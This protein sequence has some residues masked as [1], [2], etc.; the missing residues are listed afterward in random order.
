M[1]MMMMMID[2]KFQI[3]IIEFLHL[4]NSNST[5]IFNLVDPRMFDL[6]NIIHHEE[7][8][9]E[10]IRTKRQSDGDESQLKLRDQILLKMSHRMEENQKLMMQ[11]FKYQTHNLENLNRKI[12]EFVD[13]A[14][15]LISNGTASSTQTLLNQSS[16][17]D[18]IRSKKN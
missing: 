10:Q 9:S 13:H 16:M 11:F 3:F 1:M 7:R 12:G 14:K 17:K 5:I 4:V 15:L 2:I 6:G 8:N 18:T